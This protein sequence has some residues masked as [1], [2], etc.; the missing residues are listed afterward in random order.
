MILPWFY[1]MSVFYTIFTV[2]W[3]QPH[4]HEDE[5]AGEIEVKDQTRS[6]IHDVR[7][8]LYLEVMTFFSWIAMSMLFTLIAYIMKFKSISKSEKVMESDDN[9]WND[10]DTD[11]FLRYLKFEYFLFNYIL[12]K[13]VMEIFIGF[14]DSKDVIMFG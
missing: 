6:G 14:I 12:T 13:G 11:D 5:K 9:V 7:S 8:W 1:M 2:K 4:W 3:G 10:K